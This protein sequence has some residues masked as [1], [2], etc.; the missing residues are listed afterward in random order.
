MAFSPVLELERK[1]NGRT[2]LRFVGMAS[3]CVIVV[4]CGYCCYK[5]T[6][7]GREKYEARVEEGCVSRSSRRYESWVETAAVLPGG[8]GGSGA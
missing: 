7:L 2:H 1:A 5:I 8:G 6:S 4:W 3:L